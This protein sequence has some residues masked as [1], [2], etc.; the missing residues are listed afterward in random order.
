[1]KVCFLP[2]RKTRRNSPVQWCPYFPEAAANFSG[3]DNSDPHIILFPS[4]LYY[5]LGILNLALD[6]KSDPFFTSIL[7]LVAYDLRRIPKTQR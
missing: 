2:Q 7:G 4:G 6:K 1:M 5:T 3:S